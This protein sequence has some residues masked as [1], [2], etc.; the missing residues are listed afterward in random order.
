MIIR[1]SPREVNHMRR[2]G[3]ITGSILLELKS[4]LTAGMTTLEI[5]TMAEKLIEGHKVLPA[6]KGYQGYK[7]SV[8]I[9]LND[10]VVHG[11]PSA[12]RRLKEGDIVSLDFGVIYN[13]FYGDSAFTMAIGK[14]SEKTQK[15]L[16]VTEESLYKAIDQMQEGNHLHDI[17][18]AVQSHVESQGFSVVKQFVG[19]G[20]GQALHEEPPVPNYGEP[21][22][23]PVLKEGMVLA[24]EPMVNMGG[25]EVLVLDDGWTAVT[26]DHSLSAHFEHTIAILKNGPEILTKIGGKNA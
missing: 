26:K 18:H 12:E 8:C 23:G 5:D 15:L 11:I 3:Q 20:I 6:F 2:A 4:K 14:V 13:G 7:H 19:H 10:E 9:S 24:V 22:T 25:E 1:K 17:S 21:Q 16:Q